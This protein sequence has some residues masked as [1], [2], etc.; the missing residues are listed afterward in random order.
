MDSG[1]IMDENVKLFS[2]ACDFKCNDQNY[3]CY[4]NKRQVS[5][6]ICRILL[7]ISS[8][9]IG[10]IHSYEDIIKKVWPNSVVSSNSLLLLVHNTRKTLPKGFTLY[11][12]R[13]RG[14]F[15]SVN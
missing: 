14:Y 9:P 12:V 3:A 15:L 4:I 6:K 1:E 11:N 7:L 2:E 8:K 5:G 10:H 13:G